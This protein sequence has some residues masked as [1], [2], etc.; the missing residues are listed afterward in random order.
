MKTIHDILKLGYPRLY[1]MS[2]P[3]FKTDILIKPF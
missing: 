1:E 3:I 2:E